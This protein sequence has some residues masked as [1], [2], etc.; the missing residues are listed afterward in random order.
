MNSF[1]RPIGDATI[2]MVSEL[3][4]RRSDRLNMELLDFSLKN[5]RIF[6]S[7][8]IVFNTVSEGFF[9][10]SSPGPCSIGRLRISCHARYC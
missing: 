2:A 9:F 7:I 3:W 6:D 1:I 4:N 8:V 10:Q 5:G